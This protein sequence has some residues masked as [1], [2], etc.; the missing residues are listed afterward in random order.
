ME[1]KTLNVPPPLV[2]PLDWS[3]SACGNSHFYFIFSI[4]QRVL[5]L[6]LGRRET[7]ER[8][9]SRVVHAAW[10]GSRLPEG[11]PKWAPRI[12]FSGQ[13]ETDKW[14]LAPAQGCGRATSDHGRRRGRV[15]FDGERQITNHNLITLE[16]KGR[17]RHEAL[18]C[19]SRVT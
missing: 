6:R 17:S 2:A 4:Y 14:P 18:G 1:I 5:F 11:H 3:F 8:E 12:M 16:P 7:R 13:V 15:S 19:W 9:P 10:H